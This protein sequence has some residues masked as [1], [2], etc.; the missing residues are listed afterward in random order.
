MRH[1]RIPKR[2]GKDPP[3]NK[4]QDNREHRQIKELPIGNK[5]NLSYGQKQAE[6]QPHKRFRPEPD[7]PTSD[8]NKNSS[9]SFNVLDLVAK[10]EVKKPADFGD[11]KAKD[12]QRNLLKL[13][14]TRG[15]GPTF[16]QGRPS[17]PPEPESNDENDPEI[18][19][20]CKKK[21][22]SGYGREFHM[23]TSWRE[24]GY[25]CFKC[26]ICNVQ[27]DGISNLMT[28]LNGARHQGNSK[29]YQDVAVLRQQK[30]KAKKEQQTRMPNNS[31]AP[32][33]RVR[34]EPNNKPWST[35][36]EE[37][38]SWNEDRNNHSSWQT[39][40]DAQPS[41]NSQREEVPAPWKAPSTNQPPEP[42][43]FSSAFSIGN[44]PSYVSPW[45]DPV[46]QIKTGVP[47]SAQP[48]SDYY[49]GDNSP[50]AED[51]VTFSPSPPRPASPPEPFNLESD[52]Q[53]SLE[54]PKPV[55]SL[56]KPVPSSSFARK[57][58]LQEP[59]SS[60]EDPFPRITP[61]PTKDMDEVDLF[62]TGP[63]PIN[64]E[65]AG[66]SGI[67]MDGLSIPQP[68]PAPVPPFKNKTLSLSELKKLPTPMT[69]RDRVV[70]HL[71]NQNKGPDT[72]IIK[73][74]AEVPKDDD[75]GSLRNDP[76]TPGSDIY[77]P[78][79]VT[80]LWNVRKS[81]SK[82]EGK[83]KD[84]SKD[85][86]FEIDTT[87]SFLDSGPSTSK[88][89]LDVL[90][91]EKPKFQV[92]SMKALQAEPVPPPVEDNPASDFTS[93]LDQV[94]DTLKKKPKTEDNHVTASI[95]VVNKPTAPPLPLA[96]TP[97]MP[98]LPPPPPPPPESPQSEF[99]AVSQGADEALVWQIVSEIDQDLA[100]DEKL[101][102]AR[103]KLASYL[104]RRTK[105]R[106][107][108]NHV[109][110][111]LI[112]N[113]A[114]PRNPLMNLRPPPPPPLPVNPAMARPTLDPRPP[115]DNR[116][117]MASQRIVNPLF[118]QRPNFGDL[119]SRPPPPPPP[120]EGPGRRDISDNEISNFM[121][122]W[123]DDNHRG[124][125]DHEPTQRN[126]RVEPNFSSALAKLRAKKNSKRQAH[127]RPQPQQDFNNQPENMDIDDGADEANEFVSR[128][129]ESPLE[130]IRRLRSL[131]D[132][133]PDA[134][135]SQRGDSEN[136]FHDDGFSI[137]QFQR[138]Y[139]YNLP[140]QDYS[141]P[142]P[143]VPKLPSA[144]EIPASNRFSSNLAKSVAVK[145]Q[146]DISTQPPVP[147]PP[148]KPATVHGRTF[149]KAESLT[150]QRLAI[151]WS[152]ILAGNWSRRLRDAD[153]EMEVRKMNIFD[154]RQALALKSGS[155]YLV[156]VSVRPHVRACVCNSAKVYE[157]GT[158]DV[159]RP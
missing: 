4:K 113:P 88:P 45:A 37:S 155:L 99:S 30:E 149:F 90:Q 94:I 111:S 78:G 7:K 40:E 66:T 46:M 152:D 77:E 19:E 51:N 140:K 150:L 129:E 25:T 100:E 93:F 122:Q 21:V 119:G 2:D 38:S 82:V 134:I 154:P 73:P 112:P 54:L 68:V 74:T 102:K 35:R 20:L 156:V 24:N 58:E 133:N 115:W 118:Q 124:Y 109:N 52:S 65:E 151:G 17:T 126:Q 75:Q 83:E 138:Q 62:P 16:S 14:A 92:K 148:P 141:I 137:R 55:P 146:K 10:K 130:R 43:G 47:R 23:L 103:E 95:P 8:T 27:V 81:S 120:Q 26:W 34:D 70:Q 157:G 59:T 13:K 72:S 6:K 121:N 69:M 116:P 107:Q 91:P 53:A 86:G 42:R 5:Y 104:S 89:K 125:S 57:P 105:A 114:M 106:E 32:F 136:S 143:P 128:H 153:F 135:S 11:P 64:Q 56:P 158:N 84:A 139:Q 145:V 49:G 44:K 60:Y 29:N 132:E 18:K 87:K 79:G 98:P 61:K 50:M 63:V 85:L 33:R 15:E 39:P 97:S 67:S 22:R 110:P 28:H 108:A 96:P 101:S 123:C 48:F 36:N 127:V 76:G 1:S 41:W 147:V 144:S 71:D 80:P 117:P 142:M 3:K 12:Q 159:K 9:S 31:A 131:R